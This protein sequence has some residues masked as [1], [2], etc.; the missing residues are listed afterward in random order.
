MES[1]RERGGGGGGEG[2]KRVREKDRES[3]SFRMRV[4]PGMPWFSLRVCGREKDDTVN[5]ARSFVGV[6]KSQLCAH[7]VNF[8]NKC[9]H[10]GSKNACVGERESESE[11][12][13][14]SKSSRIFYEIGFNL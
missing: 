8:G 3:E 12:R 4:D 9:P 10:D 5:H 6:Q 14:E 13:D 7:V 2:I 1:G 11:R